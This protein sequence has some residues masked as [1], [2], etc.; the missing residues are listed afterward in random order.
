[1]KNK[2]LIVVFLVSLIFIVKFG[3]EMPAIICYNQA[4]NLYNNGK[5]EEAI[6]K[7]KKS[8]ELF[9][10]KDKECKIRINLALT[11]L[12]KLEKEAI[13]EKKLEIL[14]ESSKILTEKGCA[15]F[16]NKNRT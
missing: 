12:K 5:Y 13:R 4:N 3:I 8:L 6:I 1:M 16:E 7:Y 11:N 2:I 14:Q 15:G 9:P 10:S